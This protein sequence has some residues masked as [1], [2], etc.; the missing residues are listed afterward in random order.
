MI[1]KDTSVNNE[2]TQDNKSLITFFVDRAHGLGNPRTYRNILPGTL[3]SG[4]KK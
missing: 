3:K 4:D 2:L 1:E